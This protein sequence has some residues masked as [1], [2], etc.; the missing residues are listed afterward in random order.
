MQKDPLIG[1]TVGGCEVLD[2]IGQGGMGVIYKARQISLDRVVALKVLA[3]HLADNVSFVQRFQREARAVARI[4]HPNILAVYD[5][6]SEDRLNYMNMEL[7]E[8]QSLAGYLKDHNEVLPWEEGTI[9]IKQAAQGLEAAQA[10]GITHR[11]IKPE[12]LMITKKNV[13]KVADFGL[14]K[15][16]SSVTTTEAVIGTPAYMSPEQCDGKKI[17]GRSD[18]YS[19]G[20]TYYRLI[21]GHLPFEAET[22]MSMM[23]RHKHEALIP[24]HEVYR[25]IPP[26]VSQVILKMMG[27]KPPDRYQT[28]TEVIA[29]LDEAVLDAKKPIVSLPPAPSAPTPPPTADISTPPPPASTHFSAPDTT[30]SSSSRPDG[31]NSF[32]SGRTLTG[33]SVPDDAYAAIREGEDCFARGDRIAGLKQFAAALHSD[34]L[35]QSTRTRIEQEVRR[36][37]TARRQAA[38]NLQQRGMLVEAGREFRILTELDPKDDAARAKLKELDG[39]LAKKRVLENDIRTA[40]ASSSFEKAVNAWDSAPL[41]LRSEA[42]G[43]QIEAL[44]TIT[45]PSFK[46]AEQG[47]KFSKGGQLEDAIACY[48][49]AL[50]INPACEPARMGMADVKQ[51]LSRIDHMIKEGYQFSL[52]QNYVKAIETWKPVLSLRP[53]HPQVTKSLLD[54]YTAHAQR[55]RSQGDSEGAL[56]AYQGAADVDPQNRNVR[57]LLDDQTVLWEK[58]RALLD[59]ASDAAARNRIGP[60]LAHWKAIKK[61][62]PANKKAG[63]Q[64][65]MLSRQRSGTFV[66]MIIVTIVLGIAGTAGFQYFRELEW[67]KWADAQ[68]TDKNFDGAITLLR[69]KRFLFYADHAHERADEAEEMRKVDAADQLERGEKF[70]EAKAAWNELAANYSPNA[71]TYKLNALHCDIKRFNKV[72]DASMRM[73]IQDPP[74]ADAKWGQA[75]ESME[76]LSNAI[77]SF[78]KRDQDLNNQ[79]MSADERVD[80]IRVIL[81][82]LKAEKQGQTAQARTQFERAGRQIGVIKVVGIDAYINGHILKVSAT[83]RTQLDDGIEALNKTDDEGAHPHIADAV[84]FFDKAIDSGVEVDRAKD[85]KQFA[86]DLE[87]CESKNMRLVTQCNPLFHTDKSWSRERC[88]AFCI[89]RFE[90]KDPAGSLPRNNVTFA[91]A[92][93]ECKKQGKV[94]CPKD[95]WTLACQGGKDHTTRYPY[96]NAY[97]EAN[98]NTAGNA[99]VAGGS[100]PACKNAI[101]VYDMSGNVAEWVDDAAAPGTSAGGSYQSKASSACNDFEVRTQKAQDIGFRCC[102]PHF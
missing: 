66:K 77:E 59:R 54:A 5:V 12:N 73:A 20:G 78:E 91:D 26:T 69:T 25:S 93:S 10:V 95:D 11:D 8:G 90:F 13:I 18:I 62:N 53:G 87:S 49:D 100:K 7:I 47:D 23:F 36:E 79:R 46:L 39:K 75:C 45:V 19:L 30:S 15:D 40:M 55:L 44:R 61:L 102:T 58:E 60:A 71:D 38:E 83:K 1:L 9:L 4:N 94:L 98:C 68:I 42:I 31:Q 37:I 85:L 65:Q 52:E 63:Q 82:G 80:V 76:S 21:T 14:A 92:L 32:G 33:L 17:D 48:D 34:G 101:G 2:V 35:D 16:E 64:I 27:K 22:A 89:D 96:G 72:A 97:T 84:Q 50:K 28:M 24:A 67:L 51:K 57:K 70:I 56:H 29:A 81:L 43:K 3:P 41:E 86:K 99:P 6:G 88:S 74:D